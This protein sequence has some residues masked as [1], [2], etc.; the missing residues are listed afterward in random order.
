MLLFQS[1][2]PSLAQ[3]NRID[4]KQTFNTDKDSFLILAN[5]AEPSQFAGCCFPEMYK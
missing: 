3:Q 2:C 1:I 5:L 4:T